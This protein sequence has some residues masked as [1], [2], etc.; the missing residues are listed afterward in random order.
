[1]QKSHNERKFK[2]KA[3]SPAGPVKVHIAASIPE[4]LIQ[5]VQGGA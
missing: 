3:G 4:F 5:E 2:T 1:M